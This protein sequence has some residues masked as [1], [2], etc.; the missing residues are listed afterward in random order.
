MVVD[1]DR[2][3]LV[4]ANG[5]W[6]MTDKF[7][8]KPVLE[9]RV[10]LP[11]ALL[12]FFFSV[13]FSFH[14]SSSLS[15]KRTPGNGVVGRDIYTNRGETAGTT[16]STHLIEAGYLPMLVIRMLLHI[17]LIFDCVLRSRDYLI[18]Q[19]LCSHLVRESADEI[20]TRE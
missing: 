6:S 5:S 20:R 9:G 19:F 2:I 11:T 14:S 12:F 16:W 8:E 15:D 18:L 3:A 7:A 4:P 1:V 10:Q 13:K 17:V